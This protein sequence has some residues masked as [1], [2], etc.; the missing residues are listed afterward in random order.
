MFF[1]SFVFFSMLDKFFSLF[2][3]RPPVDVVSLEP[4]PAEK[5]EE[6][7]VLLSL[8]QR[9]APDPPVLSKRFLTCTAQHTSIEQVPK[10]VWNL[11]LGHLDCAEDAIAFGRVCQSFALVL[12]VS[13]VWPKL[14]DKRFGAGL[15]V[16]LS[17]S[18]CLLDSVHEKRL[19]DKEEL[20]RAKETFY[21]RARLEY[22]RL[23]FLH[24]FSEQR[25]FPILP[26]PA[27]LCWSAAV[28]VLDP[29]T[30][31]LALV[32]SGPVR[33]KNRKKCF[34]KTNLIVVEQQVQRSSSSSTCVAAGFRLWIACDSFSSVSN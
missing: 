32:V 12:R 4:S 26:F 21:R 5:E 1:G 7:T 15:S 11:I 19:V 25:K 30:T 22:M 17:Q 20:K 13:H 29:A 23:Y 18:R 16:V 34:R 33:W 6:E 27:E 10:D 24:R 2:S 31:F 9:L 14:L 28:I 3:S 8:R